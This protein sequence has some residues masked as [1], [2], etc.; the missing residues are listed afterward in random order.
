MN[1][2]R[3]VGC[4]GIAAL[5]SC[6]VSQALSAQDTRAESTFPFD[7]WNARAVALAGAGAGSVGLAFL[8]VN[9]AAV[10]GERSAVASYRSSPAGLRDYGIEAAQS[11][12]WGTLAFAIRRRDWGEV[13]GDLGLSDL[14]AGEQA[15]AVAYANEVL[16]GRVR[17]GLALSRLDQDFLG[18]RTGGWAVDLGAQGYVGWGF[19]LGA[20]ALHLGEGLG[21]GTGEAAPLP[22]RFRGSVSWVSRM[23]RLNLAAVSDVAIPFRSGPGVDLL[24]GLGVDYAV[25]DLTAGARAGW[26]SLGDRYGTG[27]SEKSLSFG[28]T[29][30]VGPVGV[31]IATAPRGVIGSDL[32]VS[33]TA[34]W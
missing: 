30:G 7:P 18:N 26:F 2:T 22:S 20:S 10:A 3:Q 29:V 32:V 14:T 1:L 9:P 6:A 11:L 8:G 28:G 4:V 24:L 21:E 5:S 16:R 23:N 31:E 15:L 17:L 34:R 33:L 13:A 27:S 19:Q 25:G 12:E